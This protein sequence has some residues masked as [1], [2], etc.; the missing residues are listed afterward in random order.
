MH[1]ICRTHG[2]SPTKVRRLVY[3][4]PP[5]PHEHVLRDPKPITHYTAPREPDPYLW[6]KGIA[7]L[8]A[9]IIGAIILATSSGGSGGSGRS[10]EV[11]GQTDSGERV[12]HCEVD[13]EFDYP[14]G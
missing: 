1:E 10:C 9:I 11:I 13:R 3:L 8:V 4:A 5:S 12:T 6:L 2:M 14:H 7:T